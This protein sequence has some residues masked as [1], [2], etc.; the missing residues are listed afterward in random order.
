M[1]V[2]VIT[3]SGLGLGNVDNTSDAAKPVSTATQTALDLK[4]DLA[5]GE[6]SGN[7]TM[8]GSETVDGRDLS[9][10]GTKLDGIEALADVTDAANVAAA[11]A[12]M[13]ATEDQALAG[14][15]AVT[16]KSLGTITTGTV[17]PDPGDRPM[18]HYT[19]GGAHTLASGAV[20]GSYLLDIVNDGSAGAITTS[21]WTLVSGD[22]FTTTDTEAFRCHASIGQQGSLLVVHALQ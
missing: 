8:A 5:G 10:D 18:Q 3:K 12:A 13:L 15:A 22:S 21:G 6:M 9:V 19:N 4:L 14:G 17:T 20:V 16:S 1:T 2:Q 11:G 7:I